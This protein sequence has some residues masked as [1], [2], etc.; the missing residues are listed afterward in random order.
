MGCASST[1]T[2]D[3]SATT[4]GYGAASL[5]DIEKSARI[6][7]ELKRDRAAQK[8][9]CKLLL[10]GSG[11][12]GKSTLLKQMKLI[13]HGAFTKDEAQDYRDVIFSNLVQSMQAVLEAVDSFGLC[14]EDDQDLANAEMIYSHTGQFEET[15][16][17]PDVAKAIKA[18]CAVPI[19]QAVIAR[20]REYQV[21]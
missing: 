3:L 14:F 5:G 1:P 19:V 2:S 10:L 21:R 17:S 12:S 20:S 6:D 18:L 13:H 4:P 11:E 9:D 7:Q 16:L 15:S 8:N